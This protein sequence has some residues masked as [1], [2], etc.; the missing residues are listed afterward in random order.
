MKPRVRGLFAF[1]CLACPSTGAWAFS[2][3]LSSAIFVDTVTG[4]DANPGTLAQPKATIAGA[5]SIATPGK[6]I[7]VSK[8]TYT[9]AVQMMSGVSLYGQYDQASNW[10]QDAANTT[11]IDGSSNPVSFSNVSG[12]THFERFQVQAANAAIGVSSYAVRVDAS[13]GPIF[14]RYNTL[15]SGSGGSGQN[16][17]AG[18][19]GSDGGDGNNGAAGTCDANAGGIG[20]IAGTSACNPGGKGGNGGYGASSGAN[21]QTGGGGTLPGPGGGSGNPGGPGSSGSAGSAGTSGANATPSASS[22]GSIVA[23][24]YTPV[25]TTPGGSGADGNGGG[26]GG[27]GGGQDNFLVIDGTGNGGGSGGGAGCGATAGGSGDGGGG[28]FALFIS[29]STV[30][31]DANYLVI[32]PAGTGGNGGDG[33]A[34]GGAGSRGLGA[35]ICTS[36]VGAGGNGGKGGKG[37]S[38]GGGAGGPGGPAVAIF[39]TS[40]SVTIGTNR[41]SLPSAAPAGTGG[42]GGGVGQGQAGSGSVG[43]VQHGYPNDFSDP[44]AATLAIA[45]ASILMS[46]SGTNFVAVP[47]S[48]LPIT[49]D[50]VGVHYQT[51]DGS[52]VAGTN[53]T[54]MSGDLSFAPWAT[55]QTIRIPIL[56]TT[57]S[58]KTF[59]VQLSAPTNAGISTFAATVTITYDGDVIFR[60]GFE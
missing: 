18:G 40:G 6:N 53:Y 49:N 42:T 21:G 2:G 7:Y 12:E 19:V 38:S 41:Y 17:G 3:D 50:F 16:G 33:A 44:G 11:I 31:V 39:G 55:G 36:E 14:I 43:V 8:G 15:L 57:G 22:V 34:G 1:F 32:G 20:G 26:G 47:V 29:A 56:G 45:D 5:L 10:T 4:A 52:A 13:S 59:S 35:L 23:G 9:E 30:T 54:A 46:Y 37:G 51:F 60:S 28:S 24:L 27:G 25:L 58:P 48:L